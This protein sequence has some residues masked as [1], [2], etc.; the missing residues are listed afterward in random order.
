[1]VSIPGSNFS[2]AYGATNICR[3]VGFTCLAGFFVDMLALGLPPNPTALEWRISFLQ[4]MGDRS[5]VLLLGAALVMYGSIESR[6]FLKQLALA[7]L[8]IGVVFHLSCILMMRDVSV[9]RKQAID[10]ISTQATQLQTQI[11]ESQNAPRS[12]GSITPEQLQQASQQIAAQAQSLTQSTQTNIVRAGF[13]SIG[14]LLITGLGLIGLG[15]YGIR[16]RKGRL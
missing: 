2:P 3:I 8:M 10:T 6:R 9:L 1:M 11:Q 5:I 15:R 12:Q 13:A 16:L 4:S 7:C 14:N